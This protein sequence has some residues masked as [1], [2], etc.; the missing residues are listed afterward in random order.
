MVPGLWLEPEIVGLDSAMLH[1]LPDDAYFQRFGVPTVEHHRRHLD[2]RHPAAREHLNAAIDR[3]V[4]YGAGYVK[5]DYNI[6]PGAGTDRTGSTGDGLLGHGR[7]LRRWL[8]DIQDR[9]PE[10]L[11]ENCAS[12]AMRMDYALLS[13]THIQSTSDNQDAARSAVVACVAPMSVLPE[14]AG[15]W[16]YPAAEM[17]DG[18]L[19]VTM[20]NG[21]A[22]RLY[23][24]GFLDRLSPDQRQLVQDAV[25]LHKGLRHWMASAAPCWPT[26]LPG[27]DDDMLTL[28]YR[29]EGHRALFVWTRGQAALLRLPAEWATLQQAFPQGAPW[30]LSVEGGGVSIAVPAGLGAAVFLDDGLTTLGLDHH[31]GV[32]LGKAVG[33]DPDLRTGIGS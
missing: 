28:G 8:L 33:A 27:W 6:E 20:V 19:A 10:L 9:H 14:Q 5:L 31:A 13:A 17:S 25:L 26:G 3:V 21:L 15:N 30:P 7:A 11:V 32:R 1:R 2:L 23:L 24:S 22:G 16:S 12:G 4:D 29:G 18:E